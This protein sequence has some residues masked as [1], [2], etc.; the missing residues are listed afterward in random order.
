MSPHWGLHEVAPGMEKLIS[1]LRESPLYENLAIDGKEAYDILQAIDYGRIVFDL[2]CPMCGHN[3]TWQRPAEPN[4]STSAHLRGTVDYK[5]VDALKNTLKNLDFSCARNRTHVATFSIALFDVNMDKTTGR[6]ATLTLQ[7][8]GQLPALADV[9]ASELDAYKSFIDAADLRELKRAVGLATHGIG[10]GAFVYLRRIFERM[11]QEA[12]QRAAQG[13]NGLDLGAFSTMRME[14]KL[15][16]V[17]GFVPDWMVQNR[18][19]YSILSVGLHE[20]TEEACREAFPAVKTGI[21]ALLEQHAELARREER[22]REAAKAL[23]K[24]GRS[25]EKRS[26]VR[27]PS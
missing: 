22:A 23:E 18:K 26:G 20:L 9:A 5:Q 3:T 19:L 8:Y 25:L 2:Y 6:A 1:L 13:A 11:V 17:K 16:A 21:I 4:Q 14:D 7:K 24:L 12:G 27:V 15:Q 10:I